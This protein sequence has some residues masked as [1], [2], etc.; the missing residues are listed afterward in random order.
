MV[1]RSKFKDTRKL[2][3]ISPELLAKNLS[4]LYILHLYSSSDNNDID[5]FK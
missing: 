3:A 5:S 1:R 4:E 2:L